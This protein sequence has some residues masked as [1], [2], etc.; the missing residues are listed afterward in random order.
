MP[1]GMASVTEHFFTPVAGPV[2]GLF[3]DHW[4]TIYRKD[5]ALL[6]FPIVEGIDKGTNVRSVPAIVEVPLQCFCGR[7]RQLRARQGGIT[8]SR[9]CAGH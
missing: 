3:G 9:S 1:I 4:Q 7:A 8:I 2:T 6:D 5:Y